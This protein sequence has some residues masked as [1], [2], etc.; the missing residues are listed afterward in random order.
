ML[1]C[2]VE[3]CD[4][5]VVVLY[6]I[7]EC[8]DVYVVVLCCVVECYDVSIVVFTPTTVS[9]KHCFIS[10]SFIL[11]TAIHVVGFIVQMLF[12]FSSLPIKWC[13]L[14]YFP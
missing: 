8:C 5:S 1:C 4:V 14:S 7:V 9:T 12:I 3:C 10:V 2:V 13:H 6:C 11:W